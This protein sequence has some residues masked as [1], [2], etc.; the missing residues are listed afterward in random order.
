MEAEIASRA[1][2]FYNPRFCDPVVVTASARAPFG[3]YCINSNA[4]TASG[5]VGL[6]CCLLKAYR[7]IGRILIAYLSPKSS[8]VSTST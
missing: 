6:N 8:C 1:I 2:R 4:R 7:E 3:Q 5:K